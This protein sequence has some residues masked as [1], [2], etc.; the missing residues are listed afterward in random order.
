MSTKAD[1]EEELDSLTL[2]YEDL[3]E[4]L[5]VLKAAHNKL[6]F[7]I[8][9]RDATIKTH[10]A[11]ESQIKTDY[12]AKVNRVDYLETQ[13]TLRDECIASLERDVEVLGLS[14]S[15]LRDSLINKDLIIFNLS[16]VIAK[17]L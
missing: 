16:K 11:R 8:K 14:E 7:S 13:L 15:L 4:E 6:K 3:D 17:D 2:D 5:A 10:E 9:N 12:L 1:L